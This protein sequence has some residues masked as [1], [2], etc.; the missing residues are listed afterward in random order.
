MNRVGRMLWMAAVAA[1][2][3]ITLA[4]AQATNTALKADAVRTLIPVSVFYRGQ[5]STTQLRNAGGVR[6]ADGYYLLSA[7]VD[8]G[9]YSTGIAAHYQAWLAS[10]V[11]LHVGGRVLAAGTYGI[12]VLEDGSM[13][14]NDIGA[15]ELL[16]LP[17]TDD[18]TLHHP[19]PL[20]FTTDGSGF[21][22]Y[23][24]RRWVR[25]ERSSAGRPE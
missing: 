12:G 23:L 8:T 19:L 15:H 3:T 17:T 14:I 10:E 6:F 21:R 25:I 5:S 1:M 2:L 20:Q 13:V 4:G 7:L 18:D 22:L 11:A 24:G 9:G 16:R